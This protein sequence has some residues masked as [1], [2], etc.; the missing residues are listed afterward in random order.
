MI[1]LYE[2]F[3]ETLHLDNIH[4]YGR[5]DTFNLNKFHVYLC[6]SCRVYTEH[7]IIDTLCS[8]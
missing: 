8:F 4:I 7:E 2:I 3:P 5:V 1:F 6:T